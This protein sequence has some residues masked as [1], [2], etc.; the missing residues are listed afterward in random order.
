M[1]IVESAKHVIKHSTSE[2]EYSP[3]DFKLKSV[4]LLKKQIK[5]CHKIIKSSLK[6]S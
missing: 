2:S 5:N 3:K 6:M 4:S 1:T